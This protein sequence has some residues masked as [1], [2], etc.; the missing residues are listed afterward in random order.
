MQKPIDCPLETDGTYDYDLSERV[1]RQLQES[2]LHVFS[3]HVMSSLPDALKTGHPNDELTSL[4]FTLTLLT[5]G[6]RGFLVLVGEEDEYDAPCELTEL[7][8]EVAPDAVPGVT[9]VVRGANMNTLEPRERERTLRLTDPARV[10]AEVERAYEEELGD[11][12]PIE[13]A[14]FLDAFA[15]FHFQVHDE[16]ATREAYGEC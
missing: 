2:H 1:V 5:D 16:R 15:R 12:G 3:V 6:R 10:R 4:M 13:H 7:L 8:S 9:F 14:A 11:Q